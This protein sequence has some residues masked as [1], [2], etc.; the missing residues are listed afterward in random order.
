MYRFGLR[1][2]QG[3]IEVRGH[4]LTTSAVTAGLSLPIN[5]I[6]TN[7]WLH[8]GVEAGTRGTTT[9]GLVKEQYTTLWL[10]ITFTPWRGE[11]WFTKPK[12]Q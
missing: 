1:Q 3:P 7:S 4:V 5:A 11:R 9:D 8:L 6:Q 10:G 2:T 12:I